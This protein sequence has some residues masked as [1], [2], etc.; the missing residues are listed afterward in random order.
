MADEDDDIM[1]VE[2]VVA[3][4]DDDDDVSDAEIEEALPLEVVAAPASDDDDDDEDVDADSVVVAAMVLPEDEDEPVVVPVVA[5]VSEKPAPKKSPPTATTTARKSTP[6]KQQSGGKKS[7]SSSKAVTASSDSKKK[8]SSAAAEKKTGTAAAAS[9]NK[10]KKKS[11]E[12]GS[13]KKDKKTTSANKVD[14]VWPVKQARLDMAKEARALLKETVQELPAVLAETTVRSFG[15]IQLPA[16]PSATNAFAQT[17]ALYP[18]GFSCDRYEFSPVHGRFVKLRC[19]ILDAAVVRKLQQERHVKPG[20]T[21]TTSGPIFRIAWG[22]GVDEDKWGDSTTVAYTPPPPSGG[23]PA[24]RTPPPPAVGWRV[25]VRLEKRATWT[26]EIIA[27]SAG[28]NKNTFKIAIRYDNGSEE[29][30]APYPD[31]DL[32]LVT[33]GTCIVGL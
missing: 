19:T 10:K 26:G 4:D 11:T 5:Q 22:L 18:A 25:R 29:K 1:E 24:K 3:E 21:Q 28:K 14:E 16:K 2:A 20:W 8:K 12:S 33:P 31:P 17:A 27:V 6:S 23:P 13:N 7:S 15:Q 32:T 9:K 30:D